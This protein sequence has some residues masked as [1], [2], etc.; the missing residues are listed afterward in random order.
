MATLAADYYSA[1]SGGVIAAGRYQRPAWRMA[2][3][4][5]TWAEVPGNKLSDINPE[6]NPAINSN[7]PGSAPWRAN[8]GFAA[9][10]SAWCGACWDE[11]SCNLW[12]PLQGGREVQARAAL[13]YGSG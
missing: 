4:A 1:P 8:S 13:P 3:P 6:N 7:H 10:I 12:L 5:G 11:A 9:I 2:M